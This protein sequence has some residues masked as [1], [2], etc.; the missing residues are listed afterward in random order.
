MVKPIRANY[1]GVYA[2]DNSTKFTKAYRVTFNCGACNHAMKRRYPIEQV[3]QA[4]P[5][6]TCP[7]CGVENY[8]PIKMS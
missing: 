3:A 5:V 6:E 2:L 1:K 4:F 8:V 7:N